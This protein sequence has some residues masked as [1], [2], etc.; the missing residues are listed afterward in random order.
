MTRTNLM[1][2]RFYSSSNDHS[3]LKIPAINASHLTRNF[4]ATLRSTLGRAIETS[5][6]IEDFNAKI[7]GRFNAV[8]RAHAAAFRSPLLRV[9]LEELIAEELRFPAALEQQ[10]AI[11]GPKVALHGIIAP[12]LGLVFHELTVNAQTFG[13][14]RRRQGRSKSSGAYRADPRPDCRCSGA[15]PG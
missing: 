3:C 11:R 9:D 12:V 8:A 6:D 10:V 2:T 4:L 7:E 5:G 15:N 13:R 1:M 14:W